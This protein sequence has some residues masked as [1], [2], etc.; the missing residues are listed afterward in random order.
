[1]ARR[2]HNGAA[3]ADIGSQRYDRSYVALRLHGRLERDEQQAVMVPD[4][5][6]RRKVIFSTSIAEMS[7]TINGVRIVIDPGLG[8]ENVYD[9]QKMINSLVVGYVTCNFSYS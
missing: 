8:K 7:V 9:P 2:L 5:N 1:M 4:P 6:G 3:G